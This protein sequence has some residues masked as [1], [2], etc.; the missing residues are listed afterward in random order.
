MGL[1][2]EFHVALVRR[3]YEGNKIK[4]VNE[5]LKRLRKDTLNSRPLYEMCPN[6]EFFLV[7]IWTLFTQWTSLKKYRD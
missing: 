7:R 6:T 4:R 2:L 3:S 5:G 1:K